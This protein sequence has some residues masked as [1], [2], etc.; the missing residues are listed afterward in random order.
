[1]KI[2]NEEKTRE[3][4]YGELDLNKG[5]LKSD[6]LFK[7][8]HEAVAGK[9][10]AEQ[11]KELRQDPRITIVQDGDFFYKAIITENS[12]FSEI[13]DEILPREAYDEY[14]DIQVYV[15]Y[16]IEELKE[17]EVK[18][19]RRRREK[20]CFPIINRGQLWYETLTKVQK[21]KLKEWYRAWLDVTETLVVPEK[22]IWL[23]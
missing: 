4:N 14:E 17:L 5:Y 8:H 19:L 15:P 16:T 23:K 1:M 21:A 12:C 22:P 18:Q 11:V 10:V 3:L 20:E 13:I 7:A 6:K 9:S 2:Y